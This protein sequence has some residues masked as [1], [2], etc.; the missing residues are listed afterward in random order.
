[1]SRLKKPP[2]KVLNQLYAFSYRTTYTKNKEKFRLEE[3]IVSSFVDRLVLEKQT[4][5]VFQR[6]SRTGASPLDATAVFFPI[7]HD[8]SEWSLIVLLINFRFILHF[9]WRPVDDELACQLEDACLLRWL[10]SLPEPTGWK[11]FTPRDKKKPGEW[12]AV[13]YDC[14]QFEDTDVNS[15][16]YLLEQMR[17]MAHYPYRPDR[18]NHPESM[19]NLR[20]D[21]RAFLEGEPSELAGPAR[22]HPLMTI[23]A[24]DVHHVLRNVPDP[25]PPTGEGSKRHT[26]ASNMASAHRDNFEALRTRAIYRGVAQPSRM[27]RYQDVLVATHALDENDDE[28]SIFAVPRAL[29]KILAVKEAGFM[30]TAKISA[31]AEHNPEGAKLL[32]EFNNKLKDGGYLMSSENLDRLDR[33]MDDVIAGNRFLRRIDELNR[34]VNRG[35]ISMALSVE[36]E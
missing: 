35:D 15:G 25:S 3:P 19:V 33:G 14:T 27:Y 28:T 8:T 29:L 2:A 24:S 5:T 22:H 13:H 12:T 16:V 31:V 21:L 11:K 30:D 26:L 18:A 1:M 9:Q 6:T 34:A 10:S 20:M 7:L 23:S 36:G 4:C 17:I 32:A